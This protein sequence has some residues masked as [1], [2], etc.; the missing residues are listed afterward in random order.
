MVAFFVGASFIALQTLQQSGYIDI[1]Y[2]RVEKHVTVV[3]FNFVLLNTQVN[4]L[5]GLLRF[6]TESS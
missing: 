2:E 6:V 5:L 4:L 3:Y 1:N